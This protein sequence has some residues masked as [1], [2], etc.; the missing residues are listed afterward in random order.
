[1]KKGRKA[2]PLGA[3][4]GEV[5]K[6]QA[7][8]SSKVRAVK[9]F[10]KGCGGLPALPNTP[11]LVSGRAHTALEC[12]GNLIEKFGKGCGIS[13]TKRRRVP[14]VVVDTSCTLRVHTPLR[15]DNLV[16]FASLLLRLNSR[17]G[18]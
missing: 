18:G 5:T 7:R 9:L 4:F 3:Q 1:M 17:V 16:Y 6:H 12:D 2:L 10:W 13:L 15:L 8:F 14:V 11:K